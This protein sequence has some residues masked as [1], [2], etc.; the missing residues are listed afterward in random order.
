[1]K[2]SQAVVK[3]TVSNVTTAAVSTQ[4]KPARLS[5]DS[6]GI[7]AF[8]E[9][10]MRVGRTGQGMSETDLYDMLTVAK[11]IF[12][13]Q[14]M[15]LE[16]E[17]PICICGD[18]HGQYTDLVRMFGKNGS[19][20]T[21][22]PNSSTESTASMKNLTV[23]VFNVMPL[24]ALVGERILCMH[25]GLSPELLNGKSLDVL[26]DII[27]PL[28]DPPNPSLPLDLLWADPD[29]RTAKFKFSIR[30]VSCTFGTDVVNSI[31]EKYGLDLIC[32]AHQ[33]VQD[34]YEFFANRKLVTIF[35]TPHYC[36]QFDNA[37]A[38][39]H[40][41][42]DLLCSFKIFRPKFPK[43]GKSVAIKAK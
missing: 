10:L 36:G 25:G 29:A 20:G 4:C 24:T 1:M 9:K 13:D 11:D 26:R 43:A 2:N 15:L 32:R 35:S 42:K 17:P 5:V 37:A 3:S 28:P 23:D 12:M 18:V 6:I 30:G 14:P 22:K 7:D 38:V 8:I 31:C 16:L 33:V 39:M 19:A 34:G 41:N 21:T 40:V 27:R